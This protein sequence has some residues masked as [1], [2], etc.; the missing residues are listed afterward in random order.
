MAR[1][2]KP[3]PKAAV[4]AMDPDENRLAHPLQWTRSDLPTQGTEQMV[5]QA[6]PAVAAVD[7]A[8]TFASCGVFGRKEFRV[9][10]GEVADQ[11]RRH[12]D[13]VLNRATLC[14]TPRQRLRQPLVHLANHL[15][16]EAPQGERHTFIV[17]TRDFIDPC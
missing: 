7:F 1:A 10:L 3:D 8:G 2:P 16:G 11:F 17:D 15:F 13:S 6:Y 5:N 12:R 4:Q 9:R 14:Q